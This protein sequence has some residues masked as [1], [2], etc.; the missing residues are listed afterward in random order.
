M[1]TGWLARGDSPPNSILAI[2]FKDEILLKMVLILPG[3]YQALNKEKF[4]N[5]LRVSVGYDLP[6]VSIGKMDPQKFVECGRHPFEDLDSEGNMHT[7]H[8]GRCLPL[9]TVVVVDNLAAL[10]P[11]IDDIAFF[12]EKSKNILASKSY[13]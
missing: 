6:E 1:S 11:F 3:T 2:T 10:R 4:G 12:G 5:R 13:S 8:C 9:G 7:I